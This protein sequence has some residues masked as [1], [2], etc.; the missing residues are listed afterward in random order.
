MSR[1]FNCGSEVRRIRWAN[2]RRDVGKGSGRVGA[3]RE[4]CGGNE[5]G[6]QCS[7][8]EREA[9]EGIGGSRNST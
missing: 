1:H 9:K 8:T 7:D 5:G 2:E 6:G 4:R 3:V